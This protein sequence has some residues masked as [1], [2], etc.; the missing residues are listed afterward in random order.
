MTVTGWKHMRLAA[1]VGTL[2]I[3]ALT[4]VA[5]GVARAD[6]VEDDDHIL[7]TDKRMF[8]ALLGAFGLKSTGGDIDYRERSP[9]VVP[10]RRDLPPPE[11]NIAERS[12]AWPVDPDVKRRKEAVAI[13]K[14][15]V[16]PDLVDP[17]KPIV[18]TTAPNPRRVGPA[19]GKDYPDGAAQS[20]T[21]DAS[22]F[23]ML[24]GGQLYGFKEEV[25]TFTGEPP[26]TSLIE[27]PPGYQ[28]PSPAAPYG[29]TKRRGEYQKPEPKL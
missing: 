2:A 23:G 19:T 12:P 21:H 9:L 8:D 4:A 6:E 22:F 16:G 29:V 7:N 24:M 15:G 27:P 10:P 18:G 13:A 17:A 28:T 3:V 1:W 14:S 25:G 20:K 5:G 11:G 26:R